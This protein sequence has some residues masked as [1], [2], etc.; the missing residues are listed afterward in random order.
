MVEVGDE[1]GAGNGV[2][3]DIRERPTRGALAHRR[4]ERATAD[5]IFVRFRIGDVGV[6]AKVVDI[7]AGGIFAR[8]SQHV[9]VGAYVEM[10]LLRPGYAELPL[11]GI[12]VDDS[13]KRA[14]LAIRF[15][16]LTGPQNT[17]LRRAVLDQH[18]RTAGDVDA[19][20]TPAR[21]IRAASDDL[22]GRD[23]ELDELRKK[24]S[25]LTRENERLTADLRTAEDAFRLI[26]RLQLDVERLKARLPGA[27]MVDVELL[28]DIKRD[29]ET[30]W[31]VI[32]RLND[33]IDRVK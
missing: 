1:H 33:N 19:D 8:M 15:E 13:I 24:L 9:P 4:H 27:A 17:A 21:L 28:S 25:H 5:D 16:G 30:A 18:V 7:S 22:V 6:V 12:V 10:V 32:A 26:G 29:A 31:N 23:R 3:L 20:V 11:S 2:S 14:G